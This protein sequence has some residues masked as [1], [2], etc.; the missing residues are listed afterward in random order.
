MRRIEGSQLRQRLGVHPAGA[1]RGPVHGG[2]VDDHELRVGGRVD[3]EL[4]RVGPLGDRLRKG[5][6][7]V[8]RRLEVPALMGEVEHPAAQ[9]GIPSFVV[10]IHVL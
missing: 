7:G 5:V 10:W 2:V 8:G 4:D 9:P 3:I 6:Q 1:V